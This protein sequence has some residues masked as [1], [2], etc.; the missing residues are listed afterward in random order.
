M[1]ANC[2]KLVAMLLRTSALE[3]L[4]SIAYSSSESS[5]RFWCKYFPLLVATFIGCEEAFFCE[6][7]RVERQSY[8]TGEKAFAPNP[9]LI[10]IPE[11]KHNQRELC[12]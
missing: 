2:R 1:T 7:K 11:N 5:L 8:A 6:C 10:Y 3:P 9:D 12:A 4:Y